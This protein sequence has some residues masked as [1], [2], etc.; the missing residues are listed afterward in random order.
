LFDL[1]SINDRGKLAQDLI[2]FLME[3]QLCSN[4]IREIAKWLRGIENL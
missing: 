4:E 2:R 1:K 3:F